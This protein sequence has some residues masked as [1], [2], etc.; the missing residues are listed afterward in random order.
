[1]S[2][3]SL[4]TYQSTGK[5][6]VGPNASEQG[7]QLVRVEGAIADHVLAFCRL[8]GD[9]EWHLDALTEYVQRRAACAPDSPRRILSELRKTGQ[10]QATCIDRS[11]SLW[12]AGP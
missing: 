2:Q 9:R 12:R 1:M 10:V 8:M 7:K 5:A 11:A 3:A 4:F 6:V